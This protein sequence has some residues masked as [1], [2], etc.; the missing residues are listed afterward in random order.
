LQVPQADFFSILEGGAVRHREVEP[1][2]QREQQKVFAV[3]WCGDRSSGRDQSV[4]IA[5]TRDS[6]QLASES[7]RTS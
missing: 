5:V 2:N 3:P 6:I 4:V 1:Q 7:I